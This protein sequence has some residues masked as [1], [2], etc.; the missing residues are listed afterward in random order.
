[1]AATSTS[2]LPRSSSSSAVARLNVL[3][4]SVPRASRSVRVERS[5]SLSVMC[6]L[7][8]V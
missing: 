3:A 4:E 5:V 7:F 6:C 2:V 1:M 8:M